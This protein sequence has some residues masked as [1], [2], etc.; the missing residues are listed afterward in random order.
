MV[1]TGDW[2]RFKERISF[3]FSRVKPVV[4]GL[5]LRITREMP[6]PIQVTVKDADLEGITI[7]KQGEP[8]E[9]SPVD[10]TSQL[11]HILGPVRFL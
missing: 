4:A 11:M 2:S 3:T 8:A 6:I 10:Y 9:F 5:P 7:V 1:T